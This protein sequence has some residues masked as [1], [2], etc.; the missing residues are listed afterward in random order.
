MSARGPIIGFVQPASTFLAA[1]VADKGSFIQFRA[2]IATGNEVIT[3][4]I[5]VVAEFTHS[6][7]DRGIN[8][9]DV[10]FGAFFDQSAFVIRFIERVVSLNGAVL[11]NLFGDSSWI[12]S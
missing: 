5:T 10:L 2:M 3:K 9:A 4:G 7:A 12:F 6:F 11:F 8:S 1:G